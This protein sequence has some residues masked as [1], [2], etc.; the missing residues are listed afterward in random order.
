MAVSEAEQA[1]LRF[2][3][4]GDVWGESLALTAQGIAA[5]GPD[6]P[7]R[8]V[9]LLA[10]AVERSEQGRYPLISSLALVAMGY[11]HL[12]RGDL[13]G[14]EAAA[15]RSSALLAGLDLDA[16]AALG[17]KVLLAQVLRARGRLSRRWPRSTRPWP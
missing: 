16:S 4:V 7:D 14:A 17:A 10:E 3:D 2:A 8:A 11:A 1:R 5:R 13:E 12:D 9:A 6:Q 15:W